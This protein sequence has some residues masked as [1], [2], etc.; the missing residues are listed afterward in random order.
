V[1]C[2]ISQT[3]AIVWFSNFTQSHPPGCFAIPSMSF[4]LAL[5][6]TPGPGSPIIDCARTQTGDQHCSISTTTPVLGCTVEPPLNRWLCTLLCLEQHSETHCPPPACYT[7][8][9]AHAETPQ[10]SRAATAVVTSLLGQCD[11]GQAGVRTLVAE[12]QGLDVDKDSHLILLTV[13][14]W[15]VTHS[16]VLLTSSPGAHRKQQPQCDV[17]GRKLPPPHV[18]E[19]LMTHTQLWTDHPHLCRTY[20]SLGTSGAAASPWVGYINKPAPTLIW[21]SSGSPYAQL[22]VASPTCLPW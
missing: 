10:E 21:S 11:E 20:K 8:L 5:L 13:T 2:I 17:Q 18:R 7:C 16:R 15:L 14:E 6:L 19:E 9:A 1:P 12:N 4:V 22:P 3:S